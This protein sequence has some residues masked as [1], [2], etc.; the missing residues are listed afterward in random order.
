MNVPY[1]VMNQLGER[2]ASRAHAE[3]PPFEGPAHVDN[4]LK[5]AVRC[6]GY[7]SVDIFFLGNTEEGRG[8]FYFEENGGS[9][10][11]LAT[12][13]DI[14]NDC[15]KYDIILFDVHGYAGHTRLYGEREGNIRE[16]IADDGGFDD[17]TFNMLYQA[18]VLAAVRAYRN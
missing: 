18:A 14:G 15:V 10:S 1:P 17:E 13:S 4:S 5:N 12:K 8:F 16:S 6:C 2:I 11:A 9:G 7:K 3:K